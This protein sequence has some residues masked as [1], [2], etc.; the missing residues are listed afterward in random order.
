MIHSTPSLRKKRSTS[1]IIS[2]QPNN[3][4]ISTNSHTS[5]NNN[6]ILNSTNDVDPNENDRVV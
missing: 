2:N 4:D 5:N 6:T 1:N 3:I